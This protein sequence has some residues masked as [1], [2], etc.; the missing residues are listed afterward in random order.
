MWLT[1]IWIAGVLR[2][3]EKYVFIRMVKVRYFMWD[4][5]DNFKVSQDVSIENPR[6]VREFNVK[7]IWCNRDFS[8][9]SVYNGKRLV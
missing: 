9:F 6:Y 1:W 7:R 2:A 3:L 5:N 4:K 8:I